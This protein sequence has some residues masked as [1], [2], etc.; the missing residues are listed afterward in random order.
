MLVVV[1]LLWVLGVAQFS[2][3]LDPTGSERN[4]VDLPL[5]NARLDGS[6]D[7]LTAGSLQGIHVTRR[8]IAIKDTP[9]GAVLF[10]RRVAVFPHDCYSLTVAGT[11]PGRGLQVQVLADDHVHFPLA[12]GAPPTGSRNPSD[13][14]PARQARRDD[15]LLEHGPGPRVSHR[16]EADARRNRH[17]LAPRKDDV[18]QH[19]LEPLG[20]HRP[21]PRA[22]RTAR[23]RR[24]IS[25][26]PRCARPA[27]EP[28]AA[29]ASGISGATTMP[30]PE[31][32]RIRA[33][34]PAAVS[35][36]GRPVAM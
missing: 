11:S 14:L 34:S 12:G 30:P 22:P 15:R 1:A 21:Q 4:G 31:C 7:W 13:L 8:G 2:R 5:A 19:L 32:S 18:E 10:S 16:R 35:T 9:G 3:A 28:R 36:T 23:P 6:G 29:R 20:L 33:A 27:S 25:P 24:P 17:L 26:P